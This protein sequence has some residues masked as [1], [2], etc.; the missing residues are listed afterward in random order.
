MVISNTKMIGIAAAIAAC[1]GLQAYGFVSTRHAMEDRISG[2]EQE[3]QTVRDAN[4]SSVTRVASDL[5]IVSEKL[6]LTE[7]DLEQARK[8]AEALRQEHAKTAKGLRQEIATTYQN[9]TKA[10]TDL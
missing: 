10:V 2:L 8:I 1:L 6:G 4:S 7:R 9:S 5:G 3:V